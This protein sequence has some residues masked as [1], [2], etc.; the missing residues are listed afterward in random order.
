MRLLLLFISA[1]TVSSGCSNSNKLPNIIIFLVDDLGW[2][3]LS[4][5]GSEFYHT[6]HIDK[7]SQEGLQFTSAYTACTVCSP[8]RASI[9][10]GKYPAR[11]HITDWIPG[12]QAVQGPKPSQK[13]IVPEIEQQLPLAETTL[14]ELL[15]KRGYQTASVGKWHL[16]GEG[17]L[18]QDQGF[19][20]NVAGNHK[21]SPPGYFFPYQRNN[22]Y[23]LAGLNQEGTEGE[24]LTDR[25]TEEA[26]DFIINNKSNP[27]FLYF[28][29][30]AV[31]T[32]IQ[33][34]ASLTEIYE[35]RVDPGYPQRNAEY[36]AMIHSVDQSLGR[37]VNLL[38]SLDISEHTLILFFSDNGGLEV[39]GDPPI[40]R[41]IGIRAGKG[42]AYEGGIRVPLIMKW[43]G[44]IEPGRVS[45]QPVIS[46]DFLPT[47][48]EIVRIPL[49]S[50]S[51]DGI[52]L[53]P[54]MQEAT[55]LPDRALYWHYP[56]YHPGGATPYSAIRAGDWKLL[57]F[58]EDG[59]HELY[60]LQKDQLEQN[61]LSQQFPGKVEE[62][63][64][65]LASWREEVNAQMPTPNPEY[66]KN[67]LSE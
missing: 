25:L 1:L 22:G 52:S 12:H 62:L 14:A 34:K 44:V 58:F 20:V 53:L 61:D 64:T 2:S 17:Y 59:H 27:F 50:E 46:N 36:A 7:L 60:D 21:G 18:P 47:I 67:E 63:A 28:P 24:Y 54:L 10:T 39:R 57:E 8:T 37:I 23:E 38:D 43:P 33:A 40:T 4:C 48:E 42:S 19:D 56:H 49:A 35:K 32:P 66:Q 3:D 29:H 45:D 65:K 13:F 31:H 11:L 55:E 26:R 51:K 6:P 5:Y 41:N 30:Y 16:G 15:K 9:L